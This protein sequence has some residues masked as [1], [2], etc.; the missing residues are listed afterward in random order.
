MLM[1]VLEWN[2]WIQLARNSDQWRAQWPVAG[3]V[4][5]GEVEVL[6]DI[7]N[8]RSASILRVKQSKKS[9]KLLDPEHRGDTFLRNVETT[10]QS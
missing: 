6:T 2:S 7:S 10:C 4:T 1:Q 5:S 8:E 9:D 3:T